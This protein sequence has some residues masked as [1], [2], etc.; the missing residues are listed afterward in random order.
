MA[1]K[2]LELSIP[3][4][5]IELGVPVSE[6]VTP[7]AK[8]LA[9]NIPTTD[10][11]APSTVVT[12]G[13]SF[14]PTQTLYVYVPN[15][16]TYT[17]SIESGASGATHDYYVD[18]PPITYDVQ[19]VYSGQLYGDT[20]E[21][22]PIPNIEY[23]ITNTFT[24]KSASSYDYRV[25]IATVSYVNEQE[26]IFDFDCVL[27]YVGTNYADQTEAAKNPTTNDVDL[28]RSG[29][30]IGDGIMFGTYDPDWY[31][32]TVVVSTAGVGNYTM[33]WEYWNGSSW[34]A[35]TTVNE[36]EYNRVENFKATGYYRVKFNPPPYWD[37]LSI[38]LGS[39]NVTDE[40][41]WIRCRVATTGVTTR[42]LGKR[43][44]GRRFRRRLLNTRQTMNDEPGV[45]CMTEKLPN[46]I[47]Y[48]VHK[49]VYWQFKVVDYVD[50]ASQRAYINPRVYLGYKGTKF[51]RVNNPVVEVGNGW[52]VVE[53]PR[54]YIKETIILRAVG[55]GIAQCDLRVDMRNI[56][57]FHR[58]V[59]D[60]EELKLLTWGE[61]K[62]YKWGEILNGYY[63]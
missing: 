48:E 21:D 58:L 4:P 56:I 31:G 42:P 44:W 16:P 33:V 50:Y 3:E 52:Y 43:V 62:E 63:L 24:G 32:V 9:L 35:V 57:S 27:S 15:S 38:D 36:Y 53:I 5:T 51:R 17:I 2:I 61:V 8:A 47:I 13:T 59:D 49:R 41:Y 22:V 6:H 39:G 45:L 34:S 54:P 40:L 46:G 11:D 1:D 26:T 25:P 19:S 55:P 18:A 37:L 20:D 28:I 7:S 30:G 12:S 14:T 10:I 60:W 29:A 23:F